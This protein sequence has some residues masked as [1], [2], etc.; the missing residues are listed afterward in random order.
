MS[1]HTDSPQNAPRDAEDG[2]KPGRLPNT[3]LALGWV[4]LLTDVASEMIFPLL[5]RFID[6]ELK[7]GKLG[8]GIIEGIAETAASLTRLPSGAL[9]DRMARRKPLIFVGYSIAGLIRPLMGLVSAPWQAL[10]VRTIDR[11]GKGMRGAPR[12]AMIAG[13]TSPDSRGRAYGFHRA[14][15]HAGAATGPLLGS[16]FLWF[17]PGQLRTLFLLAIIPGLAVLFVLWFGVQEKP[18]DRFEKPENNAR[19]LKFSL[20]QFPNNFRWFLL[21]LAVFTLG[22]SSDAFLL[23]RAEEL[24]F[25]TWQ[26]P[27]LWSLFHVAKSA[28]NHWGGR[29]SDRFNPQWLLI[30]GWLI[31]AAV[32]VGFGWATQAIHVAVLFFVYAIYYGL[33]EPAEKTLVA[34]WIAPELRGTA[35]GW[36]DLIVGVG[37]FPAS[38]VFGLIWHSSGWGAAGAFCYGAALAL[39]ATIL[40]AVTVR[41]DRSPPS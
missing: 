8:L 36:F 16:A 4:S 41:N 29:L 39:F 3:V 24:G 2:R 26:L 27:I 20:T 35:F 21:T 5:P 1:S 11:F 19:H 25:S 22:G 13:V 40:L 38:A 32:Y 14:M 23:L 9:S 12:D 17:W 31:Y 6:T 30:L 15:D 28:A 37:A 33:V 34:R 18:A 10:F 7:A